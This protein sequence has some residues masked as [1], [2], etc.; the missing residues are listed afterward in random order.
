[1]SPEVWSEFEF[2]H[3]HGD[4]KQDPW[5]LTHI[6]YGVREALL[7]TDAGSVLEVGCNIGQTSVFLTKCIR[8]VGTAA[9]LHIYDS[10]AGLPEWTPE[11]ECSSS[12]F[13]APGTLPCTVADV[14]ETFAQRGESVLPEIHKGW[15]CD[16]LQ[17]LPSFIR[18]ALLDGDLY[19][20]IRD[21]IERIWPALQPGGVIIVDDYN[22]D[23]IP[24][25]KR[26]LDE[27]FADKDTKPEELWPSVSAVIRKPLYPHY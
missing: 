17:E 20:S 16:T 26:A 1:M 12:H 5:R 8:E 11:D 27:Y 10:F 22:F 3:K 25:C 21:S 4:G 15:F 23:A 9:R 7:G 24:G 13:V 14:R 6:Y 2:R 18:F 19:K